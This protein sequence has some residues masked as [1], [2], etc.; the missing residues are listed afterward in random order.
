MLGLAALMRTGNMTRDYRMPNVRN[1]ILEGRDEVPI[2]RWCQWCHKEC[3]ENFNGEML[4]VIGLNNT[5]SAQ[6]SHYLRRNER[7]EYECDQ[8]IFGHM[9]KIFIAICPINVID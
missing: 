3:Y 9:G 1:R 8:V 6:E 2:V 5:L 4:I 7:N